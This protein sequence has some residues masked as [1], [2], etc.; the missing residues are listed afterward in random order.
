MLPAVFV[1]LKLVAAITLYR[2]LNIL[3]AQ[4]VA[5]TATLNPLEQKLIHLLATAT[6]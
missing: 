3:S 1:L 6:S 2:P 5:A 4:P